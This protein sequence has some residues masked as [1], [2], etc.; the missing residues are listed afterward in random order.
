MLKNLV[1][2]FVRD[3]RG[4]ESAEVGV[5]NVLLAGGAISGGKAFRDSI[6]E[7][8]DQIINELGSVDVGS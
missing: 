3:E 5:T 4:A 1:M 8:Q 2:N 7:K 6:K